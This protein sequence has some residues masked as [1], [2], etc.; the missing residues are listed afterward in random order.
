MAAVSVAVALI[1]FGL[2]YSKYCK[3][4]WEEQREKAT[5]G[6]LYPVFL[7]K[8]YIDELYDALFVNRAK[9]SGVAL[10]KFDGKVVDGAVNGSAWSTVKSAL[11]SSW[12]D[13]WV[14]D[15]MVKFVGGFIKTM[16]WPLRLVETG[17]TQNYA[18]VMILGV[19]IFIGYVLWGH[20]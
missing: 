20:P 10:W 5:Y 17:Y 2:A 14:V 13:R 7:N 15:G 16:S 1:G 19:L 11:G 8:Y 3:R 18:L 9:G 6:G 4:S 12:W